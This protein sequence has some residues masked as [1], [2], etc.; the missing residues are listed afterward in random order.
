MKEISNSILILPRYSKRIIAI[1]TDAGLC[2]LCTWLAFSLRLENLIQFNDLNIYPA[3]I[4][5]II[6]MPIF[7]LFGLYKMIFRY[8]GLSITFTVL[9]SILTFLHPKM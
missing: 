7:W 4:S 3:L 5:I 6:A 8:T 1:I 9:I 2:V